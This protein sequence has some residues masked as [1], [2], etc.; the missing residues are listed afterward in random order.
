MKASAQ[1]SERMTFAHRVRIR[2]HELV[3]DEPIEDGGDDEGPSPLEL[4]AASLAG[5]TAITIEMY[6]KRKRWDIGPVEV[7]CHYEL[8]ARGAPTHF[9]LVL[10]LSHACTAEQVERLKAIATR[11]P[12]H[13][14]LEGDVTF[15]QRL[16]L[17]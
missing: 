17:I 1:R 6:A 11:C 15:E 10:R 4:L 5:C 3:L 8:P 7:D 12:V 9:E 2:E 14:V 13:R 16:E